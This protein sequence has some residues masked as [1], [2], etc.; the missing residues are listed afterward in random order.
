MSCCG[1][2]EATVVVK[3]S[4]PDQPLLQATLCIELP[5]LTNCTAEAATTFA[6][7]AAGPPLH[8]LNCVWRC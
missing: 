8:L 2:R 4:R 5:A 1:Q 6:V 3:I 7:P